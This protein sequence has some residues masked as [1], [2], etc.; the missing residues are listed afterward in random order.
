MTRRN[1]CKDNRIDGLRP[2]ISDM[3][4][5]PRYHRQHDLRVCETCTS[6]GILPSGHFGAVLRKVCQA[7]VFVVGNTRLLDPDF[8]EI[9]NGV[10]SYRA[11]PA[12]P[13]DKMRI[14]LGYT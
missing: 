2:L 10:Q 4:E 14:Y 12:L 3:P 6:T 5:D 7:R 13:S 9:K 11:M 1:L 8:D